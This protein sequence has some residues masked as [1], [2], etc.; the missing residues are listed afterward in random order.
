MLLETYLKVAL[1]KA[2]EFVRYPACVVKQLVNIAAMKVK[3]ANVVNFLIIIV[4]LEATNVK[5]KTSPFMRRLEV[6][7]A[8]NLS[9]SF[10][11]DLEKVGKFYEKHKSY[12]KSKSKK[13]LEEV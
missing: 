6:H 10:I 13:N 8:V 7:Y 2:A 9:N 1:L 12:I 4:C 3:T 5:N 11:E